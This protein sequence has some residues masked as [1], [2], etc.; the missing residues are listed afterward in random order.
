MLQKK[1]D[2]RFRETGSR[3]KL[4]ES[5]Q[6]SDTPFVQIIIVT[7]NKK[8]EVLRL[9][10]NLSEIEYPKDLLGILVVDNHSTDGTFEA[11]SAIHP[12]ISLLKNHRNLGGAGGFNTGMRW[13]MENRPEAD[14][15]WLLDNDVRVAPDALHA[16]VRIMEQRPRA[17]IC[18][19]RIMDIDHPDELV[20]I[21]AFIDYDIGD[22]RR[23]E[24]HREKLENLDSIFHVDYVAACSL[25][26]RV[27]LV[28]KLGVW[29]DKF[30]IYWDDME[31]GV[32]FNAAGYDVLAVNSSVV[33]H[34]SWVGRTADTTAIWRNYYR[35]RNGLW[36]FNNYVAGMQRRCLL[37]RMTSRFM[38][39]S[40]NA[41]LSADTPLG[42]AFSLGIEDFLKGAYGKKKIVM[43]PNDLD[44]KL[45]D[46]RN[47]QLCLFVPD[48]RTS[49]QAIKWAGSLV[50]RYREIRFSAI[51]PESEIKRWVN[52]CGKENLQPYTRE[53]NGPISWNERLKILNFLFRTSWNMLITS[54]PAPKL[55]TI[56]GKEVVRVDFETGNI[57]SV[58]RMVVKEVLRIPVL[59]LNNLFR[60]LVNP[61]IRE[62]GSRT[63]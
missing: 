20:E 3:Q 15:F 38:M 9:L 43:P 17:G 5:L 21:G 25:L 48:S 51:V 4:S 1:P 28:R 62:I 53:K 63:N 60:I 50:E 12:D 29:H 49:N 61:P 2:I 45:Q 54:P 6:G 27:R 26:V 8:K 13:A 46:S 33:Y 37:A 36:F 11:V 39:Y 10:N 30:F 34:P 57:L 23:N 22:V 58:Q 24:P 18:G 14:Y 16:L 59:T 56:W 55:G 40:L 35:V 19:S 47:K 52:L 31:W 41:C 32:R 7:W 44:Q 42:H